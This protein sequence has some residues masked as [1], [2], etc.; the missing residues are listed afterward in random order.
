[1]PLSEMAGTK[2]GLIELGGE[3]LQIDGRILRHYQEIAARMR[4][5]TAKPIDMIRELISIHGGSEDALY[6]IVTSCFLA[7]KSWD[8]YSLGEIMNYVANTWDGRIIAIWISVRDNDP[9]KWTFDY[10]KETICD[11]YQRLVY[12]ES[13]QQAE[14]WLSSIEEEIT[15]SSKEVDETGN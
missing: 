1:M 6:Q 2:G 7:V 5:A 15:R 8:H 12:N 9:K 11:E 14:D 10:T 3:S 4:Q 13:A